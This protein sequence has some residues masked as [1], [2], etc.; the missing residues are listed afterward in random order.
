[1]A[2]KLLSFGVQKLCDVLSQEYAHFHGVD[3]EVTELKRELD[4]LSSFLKDA[5][6]K[7]HTSAVVRTFLEQIKEI[8]Y[9][10]EDI[11]DTFLLKEKFGKTSGI[12]KRIRRLACVFP[13]RREIALDIEGISKTISKMISDMQSFGIQQ[14][15]ADGGYMQPLH[16]RQ[17]EMRQEIDREHE[18]NFV[19]VEENVDKLLGYLVEDDNVQVVSMTGMGGL[20]KT[21]L[22][23]QAFNHEMVKHKFDRLAWVCV[24]QDCKLKNV[25]QTIL[26]NLKP[27]EEE[28][29][30]LEMTEFALHRELFGLLETSKSLIVFDDIWKEEDWSVI[31]RIFPPKKGWKVL[32]T[33]RN[34]NV[35]GHGDTTYIN[36]KPGCL[37]IEDSWTLF[38]KIAMPSKDASNLK[39]VDEEME[40][41]G[42][43][44]IKHCLLATKHTLYDWELVSENIQSHL[45]G[46]T[47]FNGDNNSLI[48]HVLS[49]SFEEL[50]SHLKHCF[51]YLAHFPEDYEIRVHELSYYWAAEEIRRYH[52]RETIRD[53]GEMYIEELVRRNMVISQRDVKT[54]RFETCHLHDMMREICLSKAKEENFLQ[55]VGI[56]SQ[57]PRSCSTSRRFVSQHPTTLD[58]EREINNSKVR[59]LVVVC[60]DNY[61]SEWKPSSLSF[62]KL[63][64]LRVLNL[65]AARFEGKKLPYSIG[66]LIHLR[67]LNLKNAYITHL[68]SSLQNLKLMLY[69]NLCVESW[70]SPVYVPNV[71]KEM[72]ELRYLELPRNMK[73]KS[74][75]ELRNLEKL[76]TLKH[77]STENSSVE[78][79]SGMYRLRTLE[80]DLNERTSIEALSAS[81]G[82]LRHLEDLDIYDSAS[83]DKRKKE[84][85]FVIEAVRLKH[86]SLE[87]YMPSVPKPLPSHLTT[88]SL[89]D[90][91]L[92]EDPMPILEKLPQLKEVCLWTNSFSGRRMVCSAGGFPQLQKLEFGGLEEWEEWIVEEGSMPL[93]H[94]L[95]IISCTK[96]EEWIVEEGSMPL[97]HTLM[98][99]GC[100]L[101]EDPMPIL[102]KLPQL[103]EVILDNKSFSG[104]IMVCSAGGFP[105]LQKLKFAGLE[106]WEEWIVEEGSMPVLYSLVIKDCK[107]FKELPD[108]LRFITSL[109]NLK[110]EYMGEEWKERLSEGGE[111]YYKIQHIPSVTFGNE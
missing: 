23:R 28:K 108:G 92:E 95:T 56:C 88:I 93:L 68:P 70:A 27:E 105:Q 33:S 15:I 1:M 75:L 2:G 109:K 44:M 3:E 57:T 45:M 55:I 82:G 47:E 32:L 97:L 7:K 30:I 91:C 31:K 110:I 74:K 40:E 58:V 76:E 41:M 69:L 54:L 11:V 65:T 37:T 25:W 46:R 21:T 103:K 101:K 71:L 61:S 96:L 52:D 78:D 90:C 98:I 104:R 49:L 63:Q 42:K 9:D 79:L 72:R 29:K 80:I 77:F 34:E 39:K 43:Q 4:L 86:L 13:D 53:V 36:F 18:S 107:K 17:R 26:Q 60:K 106:E 66:K 87:I 67:Y 59:S 102:E 6:V 81:I 51:L 12:K 50:P 14:S 20:G 85:G 48:Y 62:T 35:A 10:A 111:D 83:I 19:G 94:S 5:N 84:K 89:Q 73:K 24:S 8:I 22:A 99:E 64:L 16:D 38:Q 100:S